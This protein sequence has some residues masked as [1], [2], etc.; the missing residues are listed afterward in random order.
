MNDGETRKVSSST[1]ATSI[2]VPVA[3]I[4]A[5]AATILSKR[6]TSAGLRGRRNAR[7]PKATIVS[8]RHAFPSPVGVQARK[9]GRSAGSPITCAAIAAPRAA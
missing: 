7:R 4:R 1:S 9:R 6:A 2:G 8:C 3:V 5:P